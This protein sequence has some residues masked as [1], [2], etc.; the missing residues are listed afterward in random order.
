MRRRYSQ[1]RFVNVRRCAL[2]FPS[3]THGNNVAAADF[4]G[5]DGTV[6]LAALKC[7]ESE[8]K[9]TLVPGG[10]LD[11]MGVKFHEL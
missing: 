3:H 11:E 6:F 2:E 9:V 7:L 10:S 1:C 5:L 4:H 8:R